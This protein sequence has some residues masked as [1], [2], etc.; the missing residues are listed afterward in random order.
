MRGYSACEH[1]AK[2]ILLSRWRGSVWVFMVSPELSAAYFDESRIEG[3]HPFPVVAG[4]WN[5][6]DIWMIFERKFKAETVDK[7]KGL[8]LKKYLR[9]DPVR[10]AKFI[11]TY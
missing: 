11:S 7:P 3:S 5:P 9:S 2:T 6:V 1:L 10:F 8:S 4:F